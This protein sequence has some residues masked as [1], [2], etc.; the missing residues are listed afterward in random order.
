MVTEGVVNTI[1]R[2]FLI[3]LIPFGISYLVYWL[4]FDKMSR[5]SRIALSVLCFIIF[6]SLAYIVVLA[7]PYAEN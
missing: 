4:S 5:K 3:I 7:I 1:I 2:M 6:M